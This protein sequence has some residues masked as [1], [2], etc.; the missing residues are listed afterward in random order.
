[1]RSK[2]TLGG[3]D[4]KESACSAGDGVLILGSGRSLEKEMAPH[5]NILVWRISWTAEPGRLQSIGLQ[6]RT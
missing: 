6:S 4:G 3:S 2:E 5:S 1:M